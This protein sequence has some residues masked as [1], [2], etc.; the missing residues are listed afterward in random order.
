MEAFATIQ[1]TM[2]TGASYGYLLGEG[3]QRMLTS[4]YILNQFVDAFFMSQSGL[5]KKLQWNG[6]PNVSWANF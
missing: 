4:F 6:S 1:A 2:C 3:Y 5:T